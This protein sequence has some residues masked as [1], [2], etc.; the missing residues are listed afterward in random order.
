MLSAETL[1]RSVKTAHRTSSDRPQNR[2]CF[3]FS[4]SSLL[5]SQTRRSLARRRT[6]ARAFSFAVRM[7]KHV[8]FVPDDPG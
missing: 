2:K 6:D 1:P 3:H 4:S 5:Y 7:L 8:A